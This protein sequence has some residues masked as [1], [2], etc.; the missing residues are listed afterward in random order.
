MRLA[1][2]SRRARAH[3]AV[4][5]L[6]AAATLLPA[7][8]GA[9][10]A[11]ET[12]DPWGLCPPV[13]MPL[14]VREPGAAA[15]E[16]GERTVL[17]ADRARTDDRDTAVFEGN[18]QVER[19]GSRLQ[20]DTARYDKRRDTLEAEGEI[21][22][23]APDVVFEAARATVNLGEDSGE[24]EQTRFYYP[25]MH[26]FGEAESVQL[27]SPERTRL[28]GA[29]YSTCPPDKQDWRLKAGRIELDQGTNTGEAWN[30]TL[31]FKGLPFAYL[32]YMNFPLAGRKSGLLA[33]V[34][35]NSERAGTELA[36]P[37]YWNIAPN[38]DATITPHYIQERG[39]GLQTEFRY[40]NW[41]SAGTI[42]Y[43]FLNDD[44]LFREE[45]LAA[46]GPVNGLDPDDNDRYF[47]TVNHTQQLTNRWSARLGF[48]EVSDRLYFEDFNSTLSSTSITHLERRL[49]LN[50]RNGGLG[51]LA[52]AQDY[53]TLIE[54]AEPYRR[55]PQ[56]YLTYTPPPRPW[57]VNYDLGAEY[58]TFEHTSR[59]PTGS[60]LDLAPSVSYP[61]EGAA[62]FLTPRVQLRHTQYQ[63]DYDPA[64]A[65]P[66]TETD[67]SRTLPLYSL[68]GGLFFER[69]AHLGQT[70]L[71]QT[72]EP[73]LYYLYVP[74][75]EQSG[76]PVF[77][78]SDMTFSFAQL[79]RP[80]RFNGPDRVGDANQVSA[81]LT[82]R[83]LHGDTGQQLAW[84]SIGQI[85]YFEDRRVNLRGDEAERSTSDLIGELG[86]NPIPALSLSAAARWNPEEQTEE[87][88]AARVRYAPSEGRE[89][90]AA[91]R[92]TQG[93]EVSNTD[94][95]AL[96]PVTPRWHVL[97]RWYYDRVEE[98]S[99]DTVVGLEYE[100]CCWSVLLAG[101]TR[102][103]TN[104]DGGIESD[105]TIHLMLQLK[106]LGNIGRGLD[107]IISEGI[108]GYY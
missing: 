40:L 6:A 70:P 92:L 14:A 74:F 5:L 33:P 101:R 103:F 16:D 44:R 61:L 55:L 77:D 32:P 76:L 39:T 72:L 34:Y 107:T 53:Q 3:L 84:G 100:S 90:T 64:V 28:E 94:V 91:Y 54:G 21:V 87:E 62:W 46:D 52:R 37:Y 4:P 43:D 56:L 67:P 47:L 97:G 85:A 104:A 108:L 66:D 57:Q 15:G 8:G 69:D 79:F 19:A 30:V 27:E 29:T 106:G 42:T 83:F 18:V 82:T 23:Q 13:Q 65:A 99:L 105:R 17:S 20:A 2:F 51:F 78:T 31:A 22:Y 25:E 58:V 38:R 1:P 41:N 95:L 88:W 102:P 10:E 68:D 35:S 48:Q 7:P 80:N 45:L 89:L 73:R 93:G 75:E 81:T 11:P 71:I 86:A 12:G 49:D 98:R 59:S 9:Q 60:R 24:L 36:I 50:Y 96:W 63:L 26:A